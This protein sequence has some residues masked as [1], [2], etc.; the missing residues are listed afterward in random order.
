MALISNTAFLYLL[1]DFLGRI[2]LLALQ[3]QLD[4]TI[5]L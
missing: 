3:W 2:G 1:W 5:E 4:M